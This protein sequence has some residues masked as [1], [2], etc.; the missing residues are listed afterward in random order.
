VSVLTGEMGMVP[1]HIV[2]RSPDIVQWVDMFGLTDRSVTTCPATRDI[3]RGPRGIMMRYDEF[4]RHRTSIRS[5][6]DFADPDVIFERAANRDFE[7]VL[8]Q[9]GYVVVFLEKKRWLQWIAVRQDLS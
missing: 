7:Q 9:N 8:N 4:F 1:Y 3:P 6:C 5:A 2:E